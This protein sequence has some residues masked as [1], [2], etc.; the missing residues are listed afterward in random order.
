M[1]LVD[2]AKKDRPDSRHLDGQRTS[3]CI[4]EQKYIVIYHLRK[5]NCVLSL[6]NHE[7]PLKEQHAYREICVAALIEMA[8]GFDKANL[9]GRAGITT[10]ANLCPDSR[11]RP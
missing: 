7:R 4:T 5:G 8:E 6:R 3:N 11:S 10:I 9:S 1:T 2:Y